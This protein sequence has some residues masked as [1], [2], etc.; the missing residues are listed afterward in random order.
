M[1]ERAAKRLEDIKK[2]KDVY[3]YVTT[4][5]FIGLAY[6]DK[7]DHHMA[8]IYLNLALSSMD[9]ENL[10]VFY[11]VVEKT[12]EEISGNQ[13]VNFDIIFK[14]GITKFY[15]NLNPLEKREK[16]KELQSDNSKIVMISDDDNDSDA[17]AKAYLGVN[18]GFADDSIVSNSEAIFLKVFLIIKLWKQL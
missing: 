18:V 2:R 1:A 12:M 17:L 10:K 4:L 8:K 6:K 7:G 11:A 15:A 5:Y 16:I 13:S 14:V 3:S 9:K